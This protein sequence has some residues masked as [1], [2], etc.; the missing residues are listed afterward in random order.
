MQ[1]KHKRVVFKLI[2][3]L[4]GSLLPL[5]FWVVALFGF[6]RKYIAVLTLL[7]AVIHELGHLSAYF[8]ICGRVDAPRGRINGFRIDLSN[9]KRSMSYREQLIITLGGP[10]ISLALWV[11]LLPLYREGGYLTALGNISLLTALSS[12]LPVEGYDGYG[13]LKC[14]LQDRERGELILV[15]EGASFVITSLITVFSLYTMN[16]I[17]NG[18]WIFGVFFGLVIE[19]IGKSVSSDNFGEK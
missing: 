17:A 6:D 10:G 1:N 8:L 3:Y 15:A 9:A 2:K 5:L 7:S 11:A 19:K 4:S 12:L 14:I 16:F 18:I 13:I